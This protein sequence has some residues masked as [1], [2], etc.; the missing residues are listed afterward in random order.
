MK[1]RHVTVADIV[2]IIASFMGFLSISFAVSGNLKVAALFLI[3]A[4]F[5][6]WLD[7]KVARSLGPGRLGKE[8]DSLADIISFGVAPA[9]FGLVQNNG[10]FALLSYLV[11][12]AA[13]ILRLSSWNIQKSKDYYKNQ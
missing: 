11:F 1:F 12:I 6:D 9:I 7:G 2:S 5:L 13:G 3:T 10:I 4:V 8:I